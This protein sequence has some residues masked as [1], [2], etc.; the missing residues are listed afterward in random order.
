[1]ITP[2]PAMTEPHDFPRRILLA[3]TGVSPQVVTETLYRLAVDA[4]QPFVPTEVHLVSTGRGIAQATSSLLDRDTG[5][6][7]Q[8]LADY[9]L[10]PGAIRF[11]RETL[12]GITDSSGKVL[13]D[14]NDDHANRAAADFILELVRSFCLDD[15]CAVHASMAGGRKT[16]GFYLGYAMSLVGRAQDRLSHVLVS[17]PFES[18]ADFFYPPRKPQTLDI[19]GERVSTAD[20]RI[21]LAD[22]PFVRLGSGPVLQNLQEGA[23][24][25]CTVAQIQGSLDTP[26]LL[27][28]LDVG[29]A[30]AHGQWLD[31]GAVQFSILLWMAIRA[32]LGRPEVQLHGQEAANSAQM[33]LVME[34]AQVPSRSMAAWSR[35]SS[36]G[37][38]EFRPNRTRL[39]HALTRQLGAAAKH[40]LVHQTGKRP[41]AKY[42]L[43]LD[44]G[45]IEFKGYSHTALVN[46]VKN[47]MGP[48]VTEKEGVAIS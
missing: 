37:G 35:T 3:V 1:M 24:Y 13:D 7:H 15:R 19:R 32:R 46:G 44:A 47:A 8:L 29:K 21:T 30:R 10:D 22:I 38:E 31:L 4:E 34:E 14:I 18:C 6:Y 12:H 40:Y 27:L 43:L 2:S 33:K 20:A 5:R 11:G 25:S 42:A 17:P 26:S 41:L 39:N 23:G 9:G 45:Q 16:M 28:D 36:Y 48:A